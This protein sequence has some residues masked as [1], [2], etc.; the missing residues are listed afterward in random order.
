MRKGLLVSMASLLSAAAVLSGGLPPADS[1]LA[2]TGAAPAGAFKGTNGRIAWQSNRSGETQIW[3]M[4]SDGSSPTKITKLNDNSYDAAWSPDGVGIAFSNCCS[5]DTS[6][7]EIQSMN[8][9]QSGRDRLTNNDNRDAAPAWSPDGTRIAFTSSRDGNKEIYVMSADGSDQVD[10]TNNAATDQAP[11]WSNNGNQIAFASDRG[12]QTQV[13][14]MDADGSNVHKLT[15]GTATNTEPS[16]SPNSKQIAYQTNR[17]SNDEIWVM[18][19]DGSEKTN[20]TNNDANDKRPAWSPDGKKIA[21][22]STRSGSTDIFVMDSDGSGQIN[23][24][25]NPGKDETP[26]WQPV[27]KPLYDGIDVSHWQGTIDWPSVASSGVRF[28]FMK[29]SESQT[30]VDATYETNR[31]GAEAA[32][33]DVGAYHFA[34]PDT[35]KKDAK[36][37]ADHFVDTAQPAKGELLPVLDLERN[38]GLD[39]ATMRDWVSN[40]LS[41]VTD[42]VGVKP[43]IY[44]SAGFW[45][46][47]MD[48]TT[49]F[50]DEGYKTLWIAHW[51]T[52][53]TP[54]VPADN[55]G[56]NGW[57][58][59]QWSDCGSVPG[60]SGC[61]DLDYFNGINIDPERI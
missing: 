39:A 29:A 2:Q 8:A 11:A 45:Q 59:W 19:D 37:E 28:V 3:T 47:Y 20:L 34:Q 26:D 18:N 23:L 49:Q 48:D 6:A 31:A 51:T 10:L 57:T 53:N 17:D 36:K 21:F 12:G 40:W 54:N 56:G 27:T 25:D 14:V 50:A 7:L 41:E 22:D 30:Y 43:I 46:S 16:W 32:G 24:T 60:I 42:R 58:F 52:G 33:L 1:A 38:N 4:T 13:F 35:T 44:T 61:V 15:S 5:N 9:S 55:W